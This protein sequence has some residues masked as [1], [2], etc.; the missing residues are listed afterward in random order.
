MSFLT[1]RV[2][3]A[4]AFLTSLLIVSAGITPANAVGSNVG[5]FAS[6]IKTE[7]P[8][9]LGTPFPLA[10]S[11]FSQMRVTVTL[12]N[13][14]LSAH[15]GKLLSYKYEITN[16]TGGNSLL[17]STI[18]N[19]N[20]TDGLVSSGPFLNFY[21]AA[22]SST[23]FK[24]VSSVQA[25]NENSDSAAIIPATAGSMNFSIPVTTAPNS[26]GLDAT[27]SGNVN[28]V[29]KVYLDGVE[30]PITKAANAAAA[31]ASG[32]YYLADEARTAYAGIKGAFTAP[33]FS[34]SPYLAASVMMMV[35]VDNT[36]VGT[37]T[38]TAHVYDNG[39]D[40]TSVNPTWSTYKTSLSN[41]YTGR[42][43]DFS[44]S[45]RSTLKSAGKIVVSYVPGANLITAGTHSYD[46]SVT[47]SNNNEVS[48]PCLSG[49]SAKAPILQSISGDQMSF[50]Q[51]S[52]PTS[53]ELSSGQNQF[54]LQIFADADKANP[55]AK[56]LY[57]LDNLTSMPMVSISNT[58]LPKETDLVARWVLST[59]PSYSYT[60]RTASQTAGPW[61]ATFQIPNPYPVLVS[62]GS[63]SSGP[64]ALT[65]QTW[66]NN[67]STYESMQSGYYSSALLADG[68]LLMYQNGGIGN[69]SGRP[70]NLSHVTKDGTDPNFGGSGVSK[71][72][73]IRGQDTL[74][75]PNIAVGWT[76]ATNKWFAAFPFS[77]TGS[78]TANNWWTGSGYSLR[79]TSATL[80]SALSG[81]ADFS[82]ATMTSWCQ[83]NYPGSK[84]QP[85]G[86]QAI[87]SKFAKP[88]LV[89]S[90]GIMDT[91]TGV[92]A[93]KAYVVSIDIAEADIAKVYEFVPETGD[94]LANLNGG[95][96]SWYQYGV[97]TAFPSASAASDVANCFYSV[98]ASYTGNTFNAYH[99][100][101]LISLKMDG[102][103]SSVDVSAGLDLASVNSSNQYQFQLPTMPQMSAGNKVH[104]L[105]TISSQTGMV[106]NH[107]IYDATGFVSKTAV[108]F[109]TTTDMSTGGN[110]G[111]VT[112]HIVG[113]SD[114]AAVARQA[115]SMNGGAMNA[116]IAA[117]TLNLTGNTVVTGEA[118]V[119]R[120]PSNGMVSGVSS[121]FY[122]DQ[123]RLNLMITSAKNKLGW[124]RWNPLGLTNGPVPTV[125]S[126]N[127]ATVVA[128]IGGSLTLTGTN[129][130]LATTI[131]VGGVAAV[132][133]K[134][135]ATSIVITLPKNLAAGDQPIVINYASGSASG[136]SL[137]YLA[138]STKQI[139]TIPAVTGLPASN[140]PWTGTPVPF[141]VPT[142][143]SAGIAVTATLSPA[144]TCAM[145]NGVPTIVGAG[146]C[147]IKTTSAGDL[148]TA[149]GTSTTS[150][151]IA[152]GILTA[153]LGLSNF[154]LTD[155]PLDTDPNTGANTKTLAPTSGAD[156]TVYTYES[157]NTDICT[158]DDNGEVTGVTPGTCNIK[159]TA[160]AGGN[161]VPVTKTVSVTINASTNPNSLDLIDN[162]AVGDTPK[163]IANDKTKFVATNDASLL[164]K[165]DKTAGLLTLQSK[166]IYT[167]YILADT[168]FTKNGV[169]YTC[170]NVFGTTTAM[171]KANAAKKKLAMK[172]KVFTAPAAACK[173]ASLLSYP[174]VTLPGTTTPVA[175]SLGAD[176]AK[177]KKVAK[178]AGNKNAP[179][180]G[181]KAYEA[182]AQLQ[183]KGFSGNVTIRVIRFRAWPTTMKNVTGH[184]PTTKRIPSTIR[185][186]VIDLR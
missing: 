122:D 104:A 10:A 168:T 109:D 70:L 13:K 73:L 62:G 142:T 83:S 116:K 159:V 3:A 143:N 66:N 112:G 84:W 101:K 40:Q 186:T 18:N 74:S 17:W 47:D 72:E 137:T 151:V 158:V 71:I 31:P 175:G 59:Q 150:V 41:S 45:A 7:L 145:V 144:S 174:G 87:S 154:S 125:T 181:T 65:N 102:T 132:I 97:Q 156:G 30:Y 117:A 51:A 128:A 34:S 185:T 54:K 114:R 164:V 149:A 9:E 106:T 52:I 140:T 162:V 16:P 67:A 14:D 90:C 32:F 27:L 180:L 113:S 60:V 79:V 15:I 147:V 58:N 127:S 48:V 95:Q 134:K 139:P 1:K 99:K 37:G 8:L 78:V 36:A 2:Y 4:I 6:S 160:N 68:S 88:L 43:A 5:A 123:N 157:D 118:L 172:G 76:G 183:L 86:M 26:Q 135:T 91:N 110:L 49:A 42:V 20:V 179:T 63:G 121:Y 130:N 178:A 55:A 115:W 105:Q 148:G 126:K 170:T 141:M 100:V 44:L 94:N 103:T 53:T 22:N 93:S 107:L 33:T 75:T 167:G 163:P 129:L 98:S 77:M 161:W 25:I 92:T 153:D 96:Q 111:W 89:I 177:I 21:T 108:T 119:Y 155:N 184:V 11:N 136:G 57:E 171:S 176:F 28:F 39:V 61:S 80:G 24:Q 19:N 165:W 146:T 46:L 173:D 152:K 12:R 35:C 50:T 81:T 182:A 120:S 64:G 23:P 169:T 82:V 29:L 124:V 131:T 69:N 85:E 166:G 138:G 56:P 38:F 133:T